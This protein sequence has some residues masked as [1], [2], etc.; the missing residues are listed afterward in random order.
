MGFKTS[1]VVILLAT[2]MAMI[3][4]WAITRIPTTQLKTEVEP[5]PTPTVAPT[6]EP[7][8]L[9]QDK[10][11]SLINAFRKEQNLPQLLRHPALENSAY[12]KNQ[13]MIEN[14]YWRH[15]DRES[16]ESWYLIEQSGYHYQ[17]AGENLAFAARSEWQ[18]LDDWLNSPTHRAQLEK[19]EY[20]HMGLAIDCETYA[21]LAGGGCL[22]TLHLTQ[23]A[24]Q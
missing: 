16:L 9:S 20:R 24:S 12:A 15:Q 10:L 1:L 13:D 4:A 14:Q 8:Q 19:P 21:K 22:V 11:Y 7:I 6:L 5:T 17:T 2:I 23:P 18:V 3:T